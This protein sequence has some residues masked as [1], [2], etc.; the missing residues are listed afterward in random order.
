[1]ADNSTKLSAKETL[2]KKKAL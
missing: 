1:M 2:R